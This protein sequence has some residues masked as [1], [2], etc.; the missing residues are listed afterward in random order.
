MH[1]HAPG[2]VEE[3]LA[4]VLAGGLDH[5]EADHGVVVQDAR[6]VRLDETHSALQAHTT[7]LA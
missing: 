3:A 1:K 5:V 2:G 7:R 4:A 6:V